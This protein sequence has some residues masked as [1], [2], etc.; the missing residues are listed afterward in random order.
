M[1]IAALADNTLTTLNALCQT[2]VSEPL[3][4]SCSAFV[5]SP[6][7]AARKVTGHKDAKV[8]DDAGPRSFPDD[9][10][11][12]FGAAGRLHTNAR[13]YGRFMISLMNGAGLS[14][15]LVDEMFTVQ[16]EVPRDSDIYRLTGATGWGLGLVSLYR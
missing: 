7:V 4:L 8:A 5:R 6:C 1:V 13:D 16:A 12:T 10:P 14:S 11:M 2:K 3:I 9:T 15:A